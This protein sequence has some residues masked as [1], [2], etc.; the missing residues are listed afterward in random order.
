MPKNDTRVVCSE[1]RKR[2]K[3]ELQSLLSSKLEELRQN[4][5][6]H[7]LG[8]LS[9]THALKLLKG[10]I[11]RLKTVLAESARGEEAQV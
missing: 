11:A 7:A 3:G 6:K 9:K 2:S 10:D 4:R 8:R 5:F 1:L